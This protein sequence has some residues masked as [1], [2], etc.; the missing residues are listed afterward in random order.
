MPPAAGRSAM[1]GREVARDPV[2][3]PADLRLH[4]HVA[5]LVDDPAEMQ[6]FATRFLQGGLARGEQCFYIHDAAHGPATA[7]FLAKHGLD[8]AA[9]RSTGHLALASE[10]DTYLSQG[11]VFDPEWMLGFVR[12]TTEGAIKSGFPGICVVGEMSWALAA[13]QDVDKLAYYEGQ[14]SQTFRDLPAMAMCLYETKRF[15]AS[16]LVEIVKNHPY[17]VVQGRICRNPYYVPPEVS[18]AGKRPEAELERLKE[19][20]L[21]R[22][23]YERHRVEADRRTEEVRRL[24]E[25]D[26]LRAEFVS[27][28]AHEL[29]NPLTPLHLQVSLLRTTNPPLSAE[30]S[31]VVDKLERNVKRLT[32]LVQDLLEVTRLQAGR[33]E[34][35]F[36][37]VDAGLLVEETT[38]GFAEAARAKGVALEVDAP[39]GLAIMADGRRVVQVLYNLV[40][41]AIKYTPPGGRVRVAAEPR[42]GGVEVTVADDGVGLSQGDAERLFQPFTRLRPDKDTPGTGLG[43]FICRQLVELH[44]GRIQA[45]SPGPGKGTTFRVFLPARPQARGLP[46]AKPGAERKSHSA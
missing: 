8:V 42:D 15:P 44:G 39:R 35:A 36:S 4:H 1:G 13:E 41:N 21:A 37:P 12:S 25:V 19:N 38:E 45:H 23:E 40:S 9:A 2:A 11:G 32:F 28:A 43:L 17:V 22:E 3:D 30:Q 46:P 10:R 18:A 27:A 33:S 14:I 7:A 5:Y 6:P 20:L 31:A 34:P 26:R 16:W 29:G 24:R